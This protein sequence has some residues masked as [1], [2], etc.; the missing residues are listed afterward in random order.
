LRILR[1]DSAVDSPELVFTD[2]ANSRL[3]G[4]VLAAAEE[5]NVDMVCEEPQTTHLCQSGDCGVNAAFKN[6]WYKVCNL[7]CSLVFFCV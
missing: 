1:G 3:S 4:A 2:G 7:F 5:N 6:V